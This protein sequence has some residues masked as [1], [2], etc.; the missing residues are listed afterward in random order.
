[1][2]PRDFLERQLR[3]REGRALCWVRSPQCRI[4]SRNRKHA[5]ALPRVCREG[6]RWP[7]AGFWREPV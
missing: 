1:V 4:H 3:K 7:L 2:L 6:L 5:V